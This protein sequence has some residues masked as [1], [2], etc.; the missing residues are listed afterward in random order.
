MGGGCKHKQWEDDLVG[1]GK[2]SG[3]NW[4]G[5]MKKENPMKNGCFGGGKG[6]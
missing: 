1:V 2:K 6:Y 4:T 3:L 5:D